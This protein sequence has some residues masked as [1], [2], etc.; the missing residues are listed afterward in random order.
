MN[1]MED[2]Q[3]AIAWQSDPVLS[4]CLRHIEWIATRSTNGFEEKDTVSL[5]RDS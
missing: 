2:N 5:D 4:Q 3:A 1:I